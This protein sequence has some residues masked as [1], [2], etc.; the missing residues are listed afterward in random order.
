MAKGIEASSAHS[1]CS[2]AAG[3]WDGSRQSESAVLG[4]QSNRGGLVRLD[5]P[6]IGRRF[7]K[8]TR[9]GIHRGESGSP[10]EEHGTYGRMAHKTAPGSENQVG[11]IGGSTS[12]I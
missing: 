8:H 4:H 3:A 1:R 10:M 12:G 7:R 11:E 6:T 5:Q 9:R 2:V